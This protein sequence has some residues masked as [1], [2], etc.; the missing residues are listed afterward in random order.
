MRS[1]QW[2]KHQNLSGKEH[3]RSVKQILLQRKKLDPLDRRVIG[4]FKAC[5]CCG[6]SAPISNHDINMAD[7]GTLNSH[8]SLPPNVNNYEVILS[9]FWG[10]GS[11]VEFVEEIFFPDEGTI[12]TPML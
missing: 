1:H 12:F 3:T 11:D 9:R 8:F 7:E 4:N 2:Q 10:D 6:R 5:R